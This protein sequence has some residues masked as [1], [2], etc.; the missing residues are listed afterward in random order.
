MKRVFAHIGFAFA[1]TMLVLN[2]VPAKYDYYLMIGLAVL[3]IASL[4]IKKFR[5]AL[6]VPVC[7]GAAV[8]ACLIFILTF[9]LYVIPEQSLDG[10]KAECEFYITEEAQVNEN[11]EYSYTIKTTEIYRQNSPQNI[12]LRL[13]TNKALDCE[14][15]ELLHGTLSFFSIGDNAINSRGYWGDKIFLTSKLTAYSKTGKTVNSPMKYIEKARQG[16]RQ[17]LSQIPGDEGAL[18]RAF[19]IGDKSGISLKLYTAFK[20][21]GTAHLM[22]VSG[23]HLTAICGFLLLI[24]KK[25]KIKDKVA[26]SAA[27][28]V[29][30]YYSALCGFSKSIM[31]AGI[32]MTVL[33]LGRIINRHG[34]T[35]NS[36]GLAVFIICI[37]PFAIW[38][39]GAVLSILSVLSLCTLYPYVFKRVKL[40]KPFKNYRLNDA[41][42]Y[43]LQGVGGAAC[44]MLYSL[45]ATFIFFGY[46]SVAGLVSGII[47]I[48]FGSLATVLTLITDFAIRLKIGAPFIFLCRII[49]RVIIFSVE[50]FASFRF[51]VISFENYFGIVFAIILIIFAFCFIINR[52]WLKKAAIVSFAVIALSLVS[53]AV[54]NATSS[55]VYI[56]ENGAAAICS[57]NN[58]VVYNVASKNDYYSIKHFLSSKNKGIDYFI[59]ENE[60]AYSK[61][62]AKQFGCNNIIEN[63][64]SKNVDGDFSFSYNNEI[65]PYIFKATVD[66]V[67]VAF[68]KYEAYSNDI[69]IYKKECTDKYGTFKLSNGDII[70]RINNNHYSAR[71]VDI[72]QE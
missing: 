50:K 19:I 55:Y 66:G 69:N 9:N 12:K 26:F 30:I 40:V 7:L 38:D 35:L 63:N 53:M 21:A 8:F 28:A 25:L 17:R 20:S 11:G 29:I 45:G 67:S 15:Y 70:Y 68:N 5:Q 62:L 58:T 57:G 33:M 16:I 72:W 44:I 13:K 3:L 36:L 64:Y 49:N 42:Q 71:R 39:V 48:L 56:A 14:C 43:V 47:L 59:V 1:I 37:N 2:L 52:R 41:V 34:D 4:I 23:L 6:A 61:Q 27:I 46:I 60:N 65:R 22:A 10:R 18:S 31:R 24:M 51:S 54:V 32:M